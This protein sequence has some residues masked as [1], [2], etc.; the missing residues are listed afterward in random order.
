MKTENLY[1]ANVYQKF[2][3]C[4]VE[5][6]GAVLYDINGKAYI[7]C[8]GGYGVSLVGHCHPRI[9]KA[10]KEQCE[11]LI[12]CHGSLYND[13]RAELLEKLAKIAPKGLDKIFLSNSGAEAVECAIKAAVKYTGKQEIISMVRGY[14]GK[15]LGALS[16]TWN[17]KY[18]EPYRNLI[19]PNFKFVPFGKLEKVEGA[20]TKNTAAIIV[21][22][23][24]GEG[25]IHVAPQGFLEGLRELCDENNVILIFDEVQTGFGR[26]GRMWASEHWNVTP[27][28]MCIAKAM[29]GGLPIGATLAREDVMDSIKIGE[30]T[31]TFGG[32]PLA[33]AAAC[34]VIDVIIEENLV[35][36]ARDLGNKF[37]E[38]LQ[39]L[40]ED[41]KVLRE[42]RGLGLMLG[43]E[44]RVDVHNV[45]LKTL[46]KGV[47]LLYCG[48][49]IIRFLPPLVISIEQ[50]EFVVSVLRETLLEKEEKLEG[51]E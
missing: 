39:G 13:K 48:R 43:L 4:I 22:P 32:N 38:M 19:N 41:F 1:L 6:R 29:G 47:I 27:D 30:H 2:P 5:G 25:G 17:P 46:E 14:H 37:K 10:I 3:V 36:R 7:D 49:N 15:T 50:L 20:I 18:R 11:R 31:S 40:V 51:I 34:A 21:E 8:M 26:T 44:A 9:V 35:E 24:Q 12:A 28:I 42:A 45:L 16:A 33:C 23:I